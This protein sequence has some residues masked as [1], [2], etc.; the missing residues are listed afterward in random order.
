[1]GWK[2]RHGNKQAERILGEARRTDLDPN[3]VPRAISRNGRF[4]ARESGG[5]RNGRKME[6]PKQ[7]ANARL[8]ANLDHSSRLSIAQKQEA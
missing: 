7:R 3:S 5:K 6:R 8:A 4:S 1:L 2:V